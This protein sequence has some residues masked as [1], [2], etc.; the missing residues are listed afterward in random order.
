M[1]AQVVYHALGEGPD[2]SDITRALFRSAAEHGRRFDDQ[3]ASP[4]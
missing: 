1:A 2:S 4:A 3:V